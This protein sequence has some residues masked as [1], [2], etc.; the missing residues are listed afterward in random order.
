M[1]SSSEERFA[2]PESPAAH[3]PPL[4]FGTSGWRAVLGEEFTAANVRRV[5]SAIAEHVRETAAPASRGVLEIL[6]GYDTRF[7]S[8]RF[9]LVAAEALAD[10]GLRPL[11]CAAATPTPAVA[12]HVIRH[13]LAGAV[14]ITAS[15]NPPE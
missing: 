8:E 1:A 12:F 4:R 2:P 7:L 14:T 10:G 9:A 6:V 11:L 13:G 15:H 3:P 5:C